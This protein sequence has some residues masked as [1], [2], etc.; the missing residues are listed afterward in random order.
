M[1][2]RIGFGDDV[3]LLRLHGY[4]AG[5]IGLLISFL[6]RFTLLVKSGQLRYRLAMVLSTLPLFR[7]VRLIR[8]NATRMAKPSQCW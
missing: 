6:L 4:L 2:F 7:I 3:E 8:R 5:D 1:L